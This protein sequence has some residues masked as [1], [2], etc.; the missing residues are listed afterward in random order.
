MTFVGGTLNLIGGHNIVEPAICGKPVIF[1][2]STASVE[3]DARVLE[4]AGGG[5]RVHDA[6]EL[7]ATVVR[8]VSD[9]RLRESS[10]KKASD[11]ARSLG[12]ATRRTFDF[13]SAAI[14]RS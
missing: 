10:G 11:A 12:G 7:S 1:G 2:P 5:F 6:T 8:L 14:F 4:S 3:E 13:L 9:A